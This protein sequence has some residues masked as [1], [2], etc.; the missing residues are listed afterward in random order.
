MRKGGGIGLLE[1]GDGVVF[2][3]S[4]IALLYGVYML[5]SE[6]P[7][8]YFRLIVASVACHILGYLFDICEFLTTGVLSGG[9]L[10][11]YLGT[12]GCF[13]FLLTAG[14]GYMDEIIDDR[15]AGMKPYRW[16][17]LVAPAT[18]LVLL[19]PNL[20]VDI[21]TPTKVIYAILWL[22]AIFSTYFH[23]KHAIIPDMG[24]GFV[25]AIRPFNLAA[26]SFTFMQLIHLTLWNFFGWIPL[27]I[28]GILFGASCTVMM[29][30]A[31]R[32]V[33]RWTS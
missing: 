8:L 19:I 11:G 1:L 12:I 10:I 26:L 32:G 6:K 15:T 3:M 5:I 7:P 16:G 28:S 24:Y 30:M 23:M 31:D 4:V 33:K 9:F 18:A 25:K 29:I 17:A 20:V 13:L 14:W 22:P 21:P 2:L 27:L